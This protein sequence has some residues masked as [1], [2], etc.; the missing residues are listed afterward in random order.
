MVFLT[1][2][3]EKPVEIYG[4]K[5][6]NRIVFHPME[7]CDGKRNGAVD[8][9]TRRRYLRFARSG[10]GIIW[11]EATAV[12]AEGRAN[13]RQLYLNEETKESYAALLREMR[14]LAEKECGFVP[15]IIVQLTHSGRFSKPNGTPEPIVAY[16][17]SHWEKG[18]ENQPYVIAEDEY[19]DSI[20]VKYA[21]VAKLAEEAGFDG[22]DVKCCHGYLFN[23]F[24]SANER[25]GRYGGSLENRTKL[26]FDCIDSV[27]N[28]VSKV[29][30]TTRLNACDC[31]PYPYGY[32]VN[33][34]NEIDLSETKVIINGLKSRGVEL[35]NLT[36]GNPYLIPH[37]N[38]PCINAPEDGKIGME[39]IYS[40]TKEL[41]SAFPDIKF[42]MSGLSFE[43]ENALDYAAKAILDG[44]TDFAGFGR[45]TFAYPD[46][47]RDYLK[48][49][50]LE[51]NKVCLKCSKCTELMRNASVAGCP[52]RDSEVYMPYYRK[53]VLKK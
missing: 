8:E 25:E 23:E 48:N 47:Y 42:I 19:C 52:V 29:F 35:I 38:R 39:R 22:I 5:I 44:V 1:G 27:K 10:A 11:F 43:G 13:P 15:L 20:P 3:L 46:F 33:D 41:K 6:N 16:R 2:I 34:K 12:C 30:V 18:K 37:F 28:A 50:K 26:Y 49:G 17:N 24:L 7:G 21:A 40:V 31:F 9:L 32:G 36:L 45:M 14:E 4:K 51:K 53:D